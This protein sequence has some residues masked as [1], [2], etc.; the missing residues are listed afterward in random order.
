[1]GH[2]YIMKVNGRYL[3]KV[4]S[5]EIGVVPVGGKYGDS[6]NIGGVV[7]TSNRSE[8]IEI[9]G[10]H[11]LKIYINL[12]IKA[13]GYGDFKFDKLEISKLQ[14]GGEQTNEERVR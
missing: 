6:E 7:I 5:H 11:N 3:K 13:A 10:D 1:M 2:K 12:L 4:N 14:Q 8:A 9:D